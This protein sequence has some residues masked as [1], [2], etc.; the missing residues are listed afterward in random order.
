[1][2]WNAKGL[3]QHKSEI[4]LFLN[5]NRIDIFLISVTH[6]TSKSHLVIPGYNLCCTN[7][8]DGTA[9]GGTA[10][11]IKSTIAYFELLKYTEAEIQATSINV[12]GPFNDIAITAVYC[13][14]KHNL[15][16]NQ[17]EKFFHF[18]GKTF[19]ARGD[20]NSKSTLWGSRLTMTKG[21]N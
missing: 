18:L 11:L 1:M 17:F 19:I 8:P 12:R 7:H 5:L 6:F 10:I 4:Q 20:F 13:P 2:Q 16:A 14:P 21:K 15:K 9:H 3:N